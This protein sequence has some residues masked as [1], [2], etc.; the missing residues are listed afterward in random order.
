MLFQS[1][2][3][4]L[5]N[6]P[7]E[8]V[9]QTIVDTVGQVL[10]V[11]IAILCLD[12]I[13]E[14]YFVYQ[15]SSINSSSEREINWDL[16]KL[17]VSNTED[18]TIIEDHHQNW[19]KNQSF[20]SATY[21]AYQQANIRSTLSVPLLC[22]QDL[23][24]VLV[25]HHCKD[26][27]TWE[28]EAIRLAVMIATQAALA[29]AQVKAY[30]KLQALA[31]RESMVNTITAAIRSSLEPEA[32]FAAIT[33]E[34]GQALGVDGCTLSLWTKEDMFVQCVA[35]YNPHEQARSVRSIQRQRRKIPNT[36]SVP[37]S[38]NPILQEMLITKKPA[39]LKDLEQKKEMAR[40]ELRWHSRARALLIAPLIVD[41]EIIGSITLRQSKSSRHWSTSEIELVEAVAAQAAIA[42]Q[43]ARLYET[44]KQQAAQLQE[45]EQKVK[46]L[47][48]YLTESVLKR[49]LPEAIVDRAAVG[50]LAL[51]LS[52]EPYVVT[53]LFADLVGFTSL[54]SYLEVNTLAQLLNEYLE[55][56]AK[57]VFDQRG[58][59]DKFIGDGIMALFGAPEDL[60]PPE[61]A[62]RAIATARLMQQYL[63]QLNQIWQ[64]K[65][66]FDENISTLKLRCGIHQGRAV[67]GMFGGR[68]R[69][70]YTAVGKAVNIA[71]RLEE[72]ADPGSIL[73]SSTVA[74]WI[75]NKD[76][77][78]E[79][80]LKL[81]GIK[82]EL[83]AFSLKV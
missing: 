39:I 9:C 13:N 73:I 36:S 67:V 60:P 55:A 2:I 83:L 74:A 51:D 38:E 62:Q 68:Q 27:H 12:S 10:K 69:K 28:S 80:V 32:I 56:M 16:L 79:R 3:R 1:S 65:G 58:T 44:T 45:R 59:V 82:E 63:D 33:K 6:L 78:Q 30:E 53:I 23:V 43:Q 24:G 75:E 48:N 31:Q 25:L 4:K 57:A 21:L 54:S 35:F 77:Q 14:N 15:N 11:D 40:Y 61:Q 52:P 66:I 72:A 34:L 46:Q 70:D 22:Q 71:A 17:T 49:F 26:V 47:N 50:E 20:D 19:Q 29:I 18:I 8:Q 64:T 76:F 81:R 37:I 41:G 5:N 42:V 7:L